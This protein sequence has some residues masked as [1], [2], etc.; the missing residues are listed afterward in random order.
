MPSA[1]HLLA[2]LGLSRGATADEIKQAFRDLAQVWH[3]DRFGHDARLRAKAEEKFKEINAAYQ[4]WLSGT[5]EGARRAGA[6]TITSSGTTHQTRFVRMA[7]PGV[8]VTFDGRAG[9][10]INLSITGG[11]LL[12]DQV[13]ATNSRG[14]LVLEADGDRLELNAHVVRVSPPSPGQAPSRGGSGALVSIKF[15]NLSPK[16]QRSIPRFYNLLLSAATSTTAR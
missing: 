6:S 11:Q 3:P 14:L 8:G 7:L 12:L 1:D 4:A 2:I 15:I 9:R 13:P 10:L 5:P 16:T